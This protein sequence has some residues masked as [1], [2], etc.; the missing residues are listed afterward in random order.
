VWWVA[1][2]RWPF[3]FLIL[4]RGVIFFAPLTTSW[5]FLRDLN[6]KFEFGMCWSLLILAVC[7]CVCVCVCLSRRLFFEW[8]QDMDF[9]DDYSTIL[10]FFAPGNGMN[11]VS[12]SWKMDV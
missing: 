7:V 6:L 9:G 12:S 4:I 8:Q 5:A 10:A 1:P 2:P 3:P 11:D